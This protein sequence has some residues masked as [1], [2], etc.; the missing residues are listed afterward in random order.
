MRF[1]W[2]LSIVAILSGLA[3]LGVAI[4]NHERPQDLPWTPLDLGQPIG[5]FTAAKLGALAGD[6][7]R[8]RML[9]DRAGVEAT[10]LPPLRISSDCGHDDA[11]RLRARPGE[12]VY[13]PDGVGVACPVAAA[14]AM[15][16]W[17]VVQPAAIRHFG[18]PVVRIDHFGSY[19]CRRLY[20][21]DTG[22]WSEHARANAIDIA[23]FRLAGR[24]RKIVRVV[25][26][27]AGEDAAAAAFLRDVHQGACRLFGTTL[28]PDY[29]AAHRDHFHFDMARRSG[30]WRACR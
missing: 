9:L 2:R 3:A 27:W 21:R 24:D 20:G 25:A 6:A 16:E 10:P 19:S 15:W 22:T 4:L 1:L 29:N 5:L 11:M 7:P 14:L 28:G 26:D 30:G 8:C 23:G 17:Q 13:S 12:T 18:R